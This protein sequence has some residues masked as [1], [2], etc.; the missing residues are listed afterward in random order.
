MRAQDIYFYKPQMPKLTTPLQIINF[1]NDA[2]PD[3]NHYYQNGGCWEL[4]RILRRQFPQA[5]PYH[6]VLDIP[7]HVATEIDGI[8]YDIRGIIKR[9]KLY[10]PFTTTS[11]P[12]LN[13]GHKPYRWSKHYYRNHPQNG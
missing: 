13:S 2:R 10:Y 1:L 11:W 9:P 5:K 6:T 3:N 12:A 4:F 8:L 7:Q